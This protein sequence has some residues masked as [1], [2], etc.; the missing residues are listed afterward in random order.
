M[1]FMVFSHQKNKSKFKILE[2]AININNL[3]ILSASAKTAHTH[4]TRN[5]LYSFIVLLEKILKQVILSFYQLS[6]GQY[7][8]LAVNNQL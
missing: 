6:G 2:M 3:Y 7:T 8:V 1:N 5:R 4:S